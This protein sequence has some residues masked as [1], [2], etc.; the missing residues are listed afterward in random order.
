MKKIAF[1]I[2]IAAAFLSC[3]I[4][5]MKT[6]SLN[7]L[8]ND[9]VSRMLLPEISM[10]AYSFQIRGTGSDGGSF[11]LDTLD[12]ENLVDGLAPGDWDIEVDAYNEGH[13]LIGYGS[14]TVTVYRGDTT[15]ASI[16]VLP[17]A[18]TGTLD[19]SLLW[20]T[21]D[22]SDPVI[23]ASLIPAA[24]GSVP[25]GFSSADPGYA[26]ATSILETGYYTLILQ[27]LDGDTVVMG[28][29]ETVRI[30][31][32]QS[33]SG[34]F[35]FSDVNSVGGGIDMG[36][37][38]DMKEPIDIVLAGTVDSMTAGGS[39]T[40]TAS[41][42]GETEAISYSWYLNGSSLGSGSSMSLGS[43]LNPGVYRLDVIALNSDFTR[44]GSVNHTFTVTEP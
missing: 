28:T 41:S 17:L 23:A 24:G 22:V 18:G 33:T 44:S 29:A 14:R 19:L 30:A 11:V 5:D 7:L 8:I 16:A 2:L 9:S 34:S 3:E 21:G 12:S 43:S 36:I 27:L 40:A 6:G 10:D 35:D 26:E 4:I 15:P 25:L 39:F 31:A 38:V 37:D 1:T 20:E 42:P 32:D 13:L